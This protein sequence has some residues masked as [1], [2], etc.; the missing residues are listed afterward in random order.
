MLIVSCAYAQKA[1]DNAE[2]LVA[3]GM[4]NVTHK[5]L[6]DKLQVIAF[7]NRRYRFDAFGLKEII[8]QAKLQGDSIKLIIK[9]RDIP[10]LYVLQVGGE[11]TEVSWSHEIDHIYPYEQAANP[12]YFKVDIPIG[13]DYRY[14]IGNYDRHVRLALMSTVGLDITVA[15]GLSF[16]G[17]MGIPTFNNMDT[18]NY[19]RP[20]H[21]LM[22]KDIR[23]PQNVLASTSIGFFGRNRAGMHFQWKK[24]I[25]NGTFSI[26]MN[27]GYTTYSNFSGM[28]D[29]LP[30]EDQNYSYFSFDM[31][32]RWKKYDVQT[33]VS[34]GKFLYNDTGVQLSIFRQ[35]NVKQIGFMLMHTTLGSNGG[36]FLRMPFI[37]NKYTK[38]TKV[39]IRPMRLVPLDYRYRGNDRVSRQYFVGETL[40]N[41]MWNYY[42]S[43][44]TKTLNE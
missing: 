29:F 44:V 9:R 43:L 21:L 35:I 2:R 10:V 33:N 37:F 38:P 16:Q 27:A 25:D 42:P 34:V 32:Y 17:A 24:F 22:V 18:R 6:S 15:K 11:I 14:Q 39:R 31:G 40:L 13:F 1:S 8:G 19:L 5:E 23:L 20:T 41:Q 36:F 3:L 30:V 12:S 26:G 7:E 4:E 28:M